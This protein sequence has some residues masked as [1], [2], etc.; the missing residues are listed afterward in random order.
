MRSPLISTFSDACPSPRSVA[1]GAD[2]EARH[3]DQHVVGGLGRESR[4]VGR[5]VD[6]LAGGGDGL[7]GGGGTT[8]G[9][10]VGAVWAIAGAAPTRSRWQKNMRNERNTSIES[11]LF[12]RH[13]PARA[14]FVAC[15]I[16]SVD[17]S[18]QSTNFRRTG[19]SA[20]A[21]LP[22]VEWLLGHRDGRADR[23]RRARLRADS[24]PER[25]SGARRGVRRAR[26]GAEAA[27]L[28]HSPLDDGR[29]ARRPD[30]EHGRDSRDR[31]RRI[32]ALPATS[33]SS[34]RAKAGAAIRSKR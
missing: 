5:R 22:A 6:P 13:A 10:L 33:T 34:P 3:L 32:S 24:L 20:G 17:A 12:E 8:A 4:E 26:G 11:P 7:H 15:Y 27:R 23:S 31:A 28:R 30:R 25:H 18:P 1:R 9:S 21:S 14:T 29:A 2:G 19:K 16:C